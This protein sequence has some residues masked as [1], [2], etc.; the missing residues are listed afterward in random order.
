MVWMG[1]IRLVIIKGYWGPNEYITSRGV[2]NVR[3]GGV[4]I[5]SRT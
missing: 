2:E 3:C 4:Q 5:R 1:Y